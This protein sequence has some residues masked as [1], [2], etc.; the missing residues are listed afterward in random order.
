MEWISVHK[1]LPSENGE[2]KVQHNFP[3]NG[4][5][6]YAEYDTKTGW[7]IP[8]SIRPFYKIKAWM[9]SPI[10]LNITAKKNY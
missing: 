1:E 6:G 9:P 3:T 2:Y 5:I 8:E 10:E 7:D 4:G